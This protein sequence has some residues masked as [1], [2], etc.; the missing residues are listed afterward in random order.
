MIEAEH[1]CKCNKQKCWVLEIPTK[2]CPECGRV[3]IFKWNPKT[4]LYEVIEV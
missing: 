4:L 2:P 3:Y 1:T